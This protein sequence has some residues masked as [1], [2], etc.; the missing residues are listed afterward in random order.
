MH[1]KYSYLIFRIE[2]NR[3]SLYFSTK[4]ERNFLTFSQVMFSENSAI[5]FSAFISLAIVWG[6]HEG[7]FSSFHSIVNSLI[8]S[9]LLES[10]CLYLHDDE[11]IVMSWSTTAIQLCIVNEVISFISFWFLFILFL[12]CFRFQHFFF[13]RRKKNLFSNQNKK[14]VDNVHTK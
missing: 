7:F 4:N 6:D 8:S 14:E 1:K 2:Q 3:F 13:A 10:N 11:F 12:C 9:L 5:R